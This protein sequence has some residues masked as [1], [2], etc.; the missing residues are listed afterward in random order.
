WWVGM[1]VRLDGVRRPV[2]LGA[3]LAK[4]GR[5]AE[6]VEDRPLALGERLA[7]G[8]FV[9][10]TADPALEVRQPRLE[11]LGTVRQGGQHLPRLRGEFRGTGPVPPLEPC[12]C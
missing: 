8:R 9:R 4:R 10:A 5:A 1:V 3:D 6:Q 2:Q 12:P 11:G 7:A